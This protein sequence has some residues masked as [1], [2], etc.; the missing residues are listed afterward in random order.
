[1]ED[2]SFGR[3]LLE[4]ERPQF[5]GGTVSTCSPAERR[6]AT[7]EGESRAS[8]CLRGRDGWALG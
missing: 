3:G 2:V 5:G 8:P 1:M 6:G 4:F 7:G